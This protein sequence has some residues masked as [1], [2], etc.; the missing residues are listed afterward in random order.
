MLGY[1]RLSPGTMARI[2]I[3]IYEKFDNYALLSQSGR[4]YDVHV[5][6]YLFECVFHSE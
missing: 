3:E 6:G 2:G 1:Q 5:M 4:K